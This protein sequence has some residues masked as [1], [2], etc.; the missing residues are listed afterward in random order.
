[1]KGRGLLLGL[2]LL[3]LLGSGSA[4]ANGTPIQV[5]LQ[6]LPGISNYGP[7]GASGLAEIIAVEGDV[8]VEVSGLPPL[9]GE[10]Y[11]VWLVHTPTGHRISVGKFN[12]DASQRGR[13]TAVV[14]LART[15]FDLVVITVEP[16]P[17]PSPEPDARITL[18]GF[19]PGPTG[20]T[21]TPTP[22]RPG[23]AGETVSL[24]PVPSRLPRTGDPVTLAL[25]AGA[26]LLLIGKRLRARG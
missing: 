22:A 26:A 4:A 13:L 18:A 21:P 7:T 25:A 11:Q 20:P 16:E 9:Q 23:Q 5:R 15:A 10:L 8:R 19:V 1:M 17:D 24:P 12:T 2:L 14:D 6:Y 3:G